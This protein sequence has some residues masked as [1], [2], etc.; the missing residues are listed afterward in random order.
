MDYYVGGLSEKPAV[1]ALIGPTFSCIIGNQ[2]KDLKR[3]DRF[4]YENG[5]TTTGFT[6]GNYWIFNKKILKT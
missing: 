4:Y 3:G 6:I 2:F 5:Q 1:G